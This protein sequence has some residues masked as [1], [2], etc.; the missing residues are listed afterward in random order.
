MKFESD[1][2]YE[3]KIFLPGSDLYWDGYDRGWELDKVFPGQDA[4]SFASACTHNTWGPAEKDGIAQLTLV[5]Q[6][7]NE[8]DDWIWEVVLFDGTKWSVQGGCDYT[9]WDC[10]SWLEWTAA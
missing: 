7:Q 4:S 9:G 3:R 10:Q 2:I 1:S 6:G 5:Q 8:G